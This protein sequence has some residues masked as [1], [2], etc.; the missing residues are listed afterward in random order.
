MNK[1]ITLILVIVSLWSGTPALLFSQSWVWEKQAEG[2]AYNWQVIDAVAPN[3][4]AAY[5]EDAITGRGAIL[6]S[7]NGGQTW[8]KFP[9]SGYAIHDLSIVDS[10]N[11]WVVSENFIYHSSEAGRSWELQYSG[12]ST[13]SFLNYVEMFDSLNGV[14]MGDGLPKHPVLILKTTDGG[15]NW[16]SQNQSHFINAFSS[17]MW[18]CIQFVTPEIGY[19]RF[20]YFGVSDSSLIL[21]KT[22]DGGKTWF[23][24]PLKQSDFWTI[25]FYNEKIGLTTWKANQA[26]YRTLDGGETWDSFATNLDGGWPVDIEFFPNDPSKILI[27]FGSYFDCHSGLIQGNHLMFSSDTGKTWTELNISELNISDQ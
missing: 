2:L 4:V 18:R 12:E 21:Q 17:D 5:A 19:G 14:A 3:V 22:I 27:A 25:R 7:L 11:F 6:R 16:I 26:I 15:K 8:Q 23:P 9:W 13:T 24:L 20:S 10:L 1:L